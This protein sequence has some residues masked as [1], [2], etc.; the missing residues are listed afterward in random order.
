MDNKFIL[1]QIKHFKSLKQAAMVTGNRSEYQRCCD[2]I[3]ALN[4]HYVIR[5]GKYV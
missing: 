3:E 4:N 1:S 2:V 5:G